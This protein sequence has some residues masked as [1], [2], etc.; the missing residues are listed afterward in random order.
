V[1]GSDG[2]IEDPTPMHGIHAAVTRQDAHAQPPGG[3]EPAERLS[4][5][6]AIAAY[7][8]GGAYAAG[9]ERRIGRLAVGQLADFIVLDADP[10]SVT[11]E[12]LRTIAVLSTIVGGAVR[13]QR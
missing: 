2:P 13:Y 5:G 9:Q 11:A 6:E 4:V 7:S 1:F 8:Y 3:W 12:E 10:F